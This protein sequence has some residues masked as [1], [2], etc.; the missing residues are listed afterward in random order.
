ML[1]GALIVLLSQIRP[2]FAT[3]VRR[4][5]PPAVTLDRA[6]FT[7]IIQ[8][9]VINYLG[10]P[11]A[12]PPQVISIND[13]P[14]FIKLYFRIGNLR[15]NPPLPIHS[16]NATDGKAAI[17]YGPSCTQ[18]VTPAQ[19]VSSVPPVPVSLA[20][21]PN[22]SVA[23]AQAEDCLSI[24]VIIPANSTSD[25]NLPVVIVSHITSSRCRFLFQVQWIYGGAFQTG[26]TSQ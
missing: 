25:S 8:G 13:H 9:P 16:Y 19:I 6:V 21:S 26:D 15:F 10:I 12:Q 14:P 7:G 3:P 20:L 24:N 4:V 5:T 17:A 22:A 1:L 23:T 2:L 11:Y 18:Q